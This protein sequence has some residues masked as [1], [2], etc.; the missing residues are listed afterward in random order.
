MQNCHS[1][2]AGI[3]KSKKNFK[4]ESF[5][6]EHIFAFFLT[7]FGLFWLNS[8]LVHGAM[9]NELSRLYVLCN[10]FE[11][12]GLCFCGISLLC[13]KINYN[14]Y[15]S[16]L[17][18]SLIGFIA[19]ILSLFFI[20]NR[21]EFIIHL[22]WM[23]IEGY[24]VFF[25]YILIFYRSEIKILEKGKGIVFPLKKE[26]F[27]LPSR[28][29]IFSD[30]FILRYKPCA[31]IFQFLF[32]LSLVLDAIFQTVD[33]SLFTILKCL[34]FIIL[35]SMTLRKKYISRLILT[36]IAGLME[37]NIFF[38]LFIFDEPY[39]IFSEFINPD[40]FLYKLIQDYTI[41]F[42]FLIGFSYLIYILL[43]IRY[44][45]PSGNHLSNYLQ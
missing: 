40:L 18:S 4:L 10:F 22:I 6:R 42:A 37:M 45:C 44:E 39:F 16:G 11:G 43:D 20:S 5:K 27:T 28:H 36:V 2:Y 12:I 23:V 25:F 35:L 8:S 41:N 26:S 32:I 19:T 24:I 33:Y 29:L 15:F 34:I 7:S 21:I 17:L 13:Q 31:R 1:V 30:Q 38:S 3:N 14:T 9:E